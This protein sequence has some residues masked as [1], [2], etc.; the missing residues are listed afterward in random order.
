MSA[1]LVCRSPP[2]QPCGEQFVNRSELLLHRQLYL[3]GAQGSPPPPAAPAAALD[4]GDCVVQFPCPDCGLLLSVGD[5]GRERSVACGCGRQL[6]LAA[7]LRLFPDKY[8]DGACLA[9]R[10]QCDD[11]DAM[12]RHL[13]DAH[14][15]GESARGRAAL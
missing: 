12:E 2:W 15:T 6:D 4:A 8:G 9:C 3:H 14:G 13:A 10:R 11:H 1:D 7:V 5:A